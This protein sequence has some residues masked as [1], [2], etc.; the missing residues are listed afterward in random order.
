MNAFSVR[1][2]DGGGT[3][4]L[5]L[6]VRAP[7]RRVCPLPRC[8]YAERCTPFLRIVCLVCLQRLLAPSVR[9]CTRTTPS[10]NWSVDAVA[11][12]NG[13]VTQSS[14]VCLD[15]PF[16][17]SRGAGRQSC[18]DGI[19]EDGEDCDPGV[20]FLNLTRALL[21]DRSHPPFLSSR[22]CVVLRLTRH[23][24]CVVHHIPRRLAP[25]T[26]AAAPTAPSPPAASA[27]TPTCVARPAGSA[28]R[29]RSA[30]RQKTRLVTWLKRAPDRRACAPATGLL[31]RE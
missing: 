15:N 25:P 3:S 24:D 23:F 27:P 2:S 31:P 19:I 11:A 17:V 6:Y 14:N 10:G 20:R 29:G 12:L 21:L 4:P 26:P 22:A 1:L 28:R 16:D 13:N 18:G 30:A 7:D 5:Q 8:P 9:C